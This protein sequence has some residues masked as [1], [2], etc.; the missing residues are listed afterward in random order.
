MACTSPRTVGF[1]ADG[2]TISWSPKNYSREYAP[3]QLPCGKCVECRFAY[4]RE[5]AIRC[6]HEASMYEKNC[7]ITLTYSDQHLKSPKLIYEDFQKFMR[8]LRKLQNEPIPMFVTGEYGEKNKRPH[9]HAIIFNFAPPDLVPYRTN[10]RGDTLT[11][12]VLLDNLWGK[13]DPKT[14]P[15]QIGKVTMESAGY[16]ARYSSKKL[17]HGLDG[18]H[19]YNP[20]SKKSSKHAIG[21]KWLE[22]YYKDIFDYGILH[23]ANGSTAP[24]PRY[25]E[26]WFKQEHPEEYTRYLTT[27]KMLKAEA[28]AKLS[29]QDDADWLAN[30]AVRTANGKGLHPAKKKREIRKLIANEKHKMLQNYLKL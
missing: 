29:A 30:Q 7:F 24:I 11:T 15:I 20:I 12:S 8:K 14:Q 26:K 17:V 22:K 16:V 25:Y 18:T 13:N 28:A 4:A 6:V 19:D 27:T 3:F 10:D 2:K 9:W 5:W 21:K 1:E 23:L